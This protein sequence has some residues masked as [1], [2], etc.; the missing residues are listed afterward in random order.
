MARAMWSGAINFG[1]VT[2]P[3]KLYKATGEKSMSLN[4]LHKKCGS[5]IREKRWCPTCDN[6]V[7]WDDL[8][9]G[10]EFTKDNYVILTDEDLETL[11]ET[12]K[13]VVQIE[14]F[15]NLSDIDPIYYDSAYYTQPDKVA[16]GS[17]SLLLDSLKDKKMI[18]LGRITL[19]TKQRLC[20]LRPHEDLLLVETLYYPE[21]IRL[22]DS[23]SFE[24]SKPS[25]KDLK[26]A[27]QLI[28]LM[29][30]EFEPK[31]YKDEYREAL[32]SLIESK[33]NDQEISVQP[34]VEASKIVDLTEA[35]RA[36]LSEVKGES[37]ASRSKRSQKPKTRTAAKVSRGPDTGTLSDKSK[38]KKKST[39][40][41]ES[42]TSKSA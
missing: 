23:P 34:S 39:K 28:D 15:L 30:S 5:R 13:K 3:V 26:M 1:M 14:S 38:K 37:G 33:V 10:Y 4:L 9:R 42:K 7:N 27:S 36:S 35:L 41:S 29:A 8:V 20:I 24:Y 16:S 12:M 2:I 25:E 32:E 31:N 18:A 19:R 11:P 40:K 22:D 17:Y 21:E 6:E